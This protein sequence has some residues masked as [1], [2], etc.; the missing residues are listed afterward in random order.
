MR[1]WFKT[2]PASPHVQGYNVAPGTDNVART[3]TLKNW[4]SYIPIVEVWR[5]YRKGDLPGDIIAGFA[6]GAV[7]I[8][9]AIAYAFLA[10]LPAQAGLY[11][12]LLPP[13][14]YAVLGSSRHLVVGP[15]AVAALMVSAT[16]SEHA[17]AFSNEYLAITT[18]LCLQVGFILW[19]L[20]IF[21]LGGI[22]NLL[23][24]PVVGGFVNAAAIIIIIS[25]LPALTGVVPVRADTAFE[26]LAAL[27]SVLDNVDPAALG[28]GALS[29]VL[30]WIMRHRAYRLF[31]NAPRRHPISRTGAMLAVVACGGLV[32]LFDL[33]VPT[34]GAVP[35]GLPT[36]T[37]PP[38]EVDLWLA[39]MPNSM[40]IA[41]V[42][43]VESY[44]VGKAFA[45]HEHRRVNSHQ[46]L[47]ALG[48]ANIGAA[49]TGAYPAAGSFSRT[50]VNHQAGGRTPF[51]GLVCAVVV[52]VTLLW[53]MPAFEYLPHATLAVIIIVS[54]FSLFDFRSFTEHWRFYRADVFTH[55][56]TFLGVL[57]FGVA[58]GLLIGV[59]IS[60]VLFVRRSSRPHITVVGRLEDSPHFRSVERFEVQTFPG[61]ALVRI[62][63]GLYFANVNAIESHLIKVAER[64]EDIEHMVLVCSG[65]NF[66]DTSGLEM[67]K[68]LASRFRGLQ[69]TL[70]LSEL[71]GPVRDQID[72]I[73][74]K[75]Y[76]SGHAFP[77]TDEAL[78]HLME[79][80]T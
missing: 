20:R 76:L 6:L 37:L 51:S 74:L 53:F 67:L 52:V 17:A 69:V 14:I 12:C 32:W 2:A 13:V 75:E 70:H 78:R 58:P 66:I 61:V 49:F 1:G 45:S 40:L 56:A 80:G 29:F 42:A 28:I 26:Q 8:P 72:T 19:L 11:T 38:F 30:I 68:R 10:G 27:G 48:A 63:E 73:V 57:A 54:V 77:T 31:R 62:D 43:Y 25:Q 46:E 60:V 7:T 21:Q 36:L 24:H 59:A 64:Q 16:V 18:V 41:L 22:V 44:T 34:V 15:V 5:D 35:A 47:I 65:I 71:K 23:S 55:L 79:R 9:Q 3:L 4:P 50:G 39:L 33:S